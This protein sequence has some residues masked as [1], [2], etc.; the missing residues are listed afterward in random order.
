MLVELIGH[1]GSG[2]S[3]LLAEIDSTSDP[4]FSSMLTNQEYQ[5]LDRARGERSIMK[6]S[7]LRRWI[8][9]LPVFWRHPRL[10]SRVVVLMILHGRPFFRRLRKAERLLAH[11][12][13]TDELLET[14]PGRIIV[15][16]DGFLQCLW[17]MLIESRSLRG[18]R[19][20]ESLFEIY[21]LPRNP[22]LVG[23]EVDDRIATR[24]VFNRISRGR[25]N[26]DSSPRRRA[27]FGKWL[28]RHHELV[29][30]LPASLRRERIDGDGTVSCVMSEFAAVLDRHMPRLLRRPTRSAVASRQSA[31]LTTAPRRIR[32]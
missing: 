1:P 7:R 9:V 15:H 4:T 5:E 14:F 12:I 11:V 16:Q 31:N 27:E 3:T 22:L 23:L 6:S 18:T 2:K 10:A 30:L 21:Y 24:R 19:L 28:A 13:F 32:P 20:I 29:E 26:R 8:R 25:F 17:S